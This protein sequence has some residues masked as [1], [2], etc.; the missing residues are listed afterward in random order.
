MI[1]SWEH[2]AYGTG[3]GLLVLLAGCIDLPKDTKFCSCNNRTVLITNLCGCP[4]EPLN[5][6]IPDL[7][8]TN[9]TTTTTESIYGN[10]DF[11]ISPSG[12]WEKHEGFWTEGN[13]TCKDDICIHNDMFK[14]YE[15]YKTEVEGK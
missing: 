6:K 2:F 3:I 5:Q 12:I 10:F 9:N 13:F 8:L 15:Y 4:G 7:N 14:I 1:N 11:S